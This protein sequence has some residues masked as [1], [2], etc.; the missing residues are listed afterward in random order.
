[1]FDFRETSGFVLSIGYL[2]FMLLLNMKSRYFYKKLE[3]NFDILI[4]DVLEISDTLDLDM[5]GIGY[6]YE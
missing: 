3:F 2:R 1:M 6:G 5:N 4:V